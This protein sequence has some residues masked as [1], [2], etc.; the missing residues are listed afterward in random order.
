MTTSSNP[1][2][3]TKTVTQRDQAITAAYGSAGDSITH[4]AATSRV[5]VGN[6]LSPKWEIQYRVGSGAWE[7]VG[8]GKSKWLDIDLS[9]TTLKVRRSEFAPAS[10]T[11]GLIIEGLP[12]SLVADTG[13]GAT[14]D[15]GAVSADGISEIAP[16]MPNVLFRFDGSVAAGVGYTV[17]HSGTGG[18]NSIDTAT[19]P[20]VGLNAGASLKINAGSTRTDVDITGLN[21]V[22]FDGHVVINCWVED[23]T[24]T[25]MQLTAFAGTSGLGRSFQRMHTVVAGTGTAPRNGFHAVPC[26]PLENNDVS[27]S[28]AIWTAG[29]SSTFLVGVDSLGQVRLRINGD[30]VG[31]RTGAVWIHSISLVP[32]GTPTVVFS[33]DDA[34]RWVDAAIPHLNANGIMGTFGVMS[35][36]IGGTPSLWL[37]VA[38]LQAMAAAGH[39]ICSHNVANT[40]LQSPYDAAA[41]DTYAAA[42][43]S[44]LVALQGWIGDK[45]SSIYHPWVQG[46]SSDTAVKRLRSYGCRIARMAGQARHNIITSA[47]GGGVFDGVMQLR[48]IWT[49][50]GSAGAGPNFTN[51]VVDQILNDCEKYGTT[52]CFMINE[53]QD[54]ETGYQTSVAKH[55]YIVEQ[56]ASRTGI[57]KLT[58]GQLYKRLAAQGLVV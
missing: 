48:S 15:V 38:E 4:S 56:S 53:V 37:R 2:S 29:A 36:G 1:V 6:L 26:G 33:Y 52:V 45:A 57:Q 16:I 24:A 9:T 13:G 46:V 47:P 40:A 7:T 54:A 23:H 18:T 34:S 30:G 50:D 41:A 28:T 39:E 10:V 55:R 21:L 5:Q 8:P 49:Y 14:V 42:F 35:S 25:S 22:N 44:G 11:V 3:A 27:N 51:A 12:T 19:S 20:F 32:R 17:T 43:R 58:M 31:T